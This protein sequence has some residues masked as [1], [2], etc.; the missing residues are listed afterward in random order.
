MEDDA[1]VH[2]SCFGTK[3]RQ[4]KSEDD[5]DRQPD[6]QPVAEPEGERSPDDRDPAPPATEQEEA[7]AAVGQLLDDR[8]AKL[9]TAT[10]L[11]AY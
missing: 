4:A 11:S 10:K 2:A 3:P 8:R 7:G 1:R 6:D 9:A 5:E